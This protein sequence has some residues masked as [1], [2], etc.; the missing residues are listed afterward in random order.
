ME[1]GDEGADDSGHFGVA[2]FG[3]EASVDPVARAA[4]DE[5]IERRALGAVVTLSVLRREPGL[6]GAGPRGLT[7]RYPVE[8]RPP[9]LGAAHGA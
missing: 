5:R 6:V 8:R 9:N 3:F 4:H 1:E 2:G 7:S